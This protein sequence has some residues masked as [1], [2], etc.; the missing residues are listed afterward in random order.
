MPSSN[1]LI[2]LTG[3]SPPLCLPLPPEP[4]MNSYLSMIKGNSLPKVSMDRLDV[5][6]ICT[7]GL[8]PCRDGDT[9]TTPEPLILLE[10]KH[11]YYFFSFSKNSEN[12]HQK[13]LKR[14]IKIK[15]VI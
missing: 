15:I 6:V 5:L 1:T 12:Y 2:S 8:H 3:P 7:P 14:S 13:D 9:T 4:I 11:F 10:F